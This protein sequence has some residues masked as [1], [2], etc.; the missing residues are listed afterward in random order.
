MG[1]L[2]YESMKEVE[3]M[4]T[5]GYIYFDENGDHNGMVKIERMQG[6]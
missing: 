4:G 2:I 3:F 6:W 1:N 5:K